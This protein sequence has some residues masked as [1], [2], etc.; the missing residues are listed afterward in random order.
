MAARFGS[1]RTGRVASTVVC[2]QPSCHGPRTRTVAGPRTTSPRA[3]GVTVYSTAAGRCT[4]HR[5]REACSP[6][7]T[8]SCTI[9]DA[10]A[11]RALI[12]SVTRLATPTERRSVDSRSTR[13]SDLP[14]ARRESTTIAPTHATRST[15]PARNRPGTAAPP[16]MTA[17]GTSSSPAPRQVI[18]ARSPGDRDPA[19]GALHGGDL[20]HALDLRLGA[21]NHP[22]PKC[23]DP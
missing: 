7:V 1:T 19:H 16:A 3:T 2:R 17:T 11:E 21:A 10:P 4:F 9:A 23:R 14:G 22:V 12:R 15:S 5:V 18:A 20:G 8:F 6:G 13:N